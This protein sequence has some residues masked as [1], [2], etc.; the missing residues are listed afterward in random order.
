MG[1]SSA[2]LIAFV[3]TFLAGV[4]LSG[5]VAVNGMLSKM[6]TGPLWAAF[7]SFL[8]G[9]IAL[10]LLLIVLR[11]PPPTI[12]S[13]SKLPKWYFIG[14]FLGVFY[15]TIVTLSIGV[16]GSVSLITTVIIAQLITATALEHFGLLG[17]PKSPV[18]LKTLL[19]FGLMLTGFSMIK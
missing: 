18:Q 19:G 4:A 2:V 14:G 13:L 1:F 15:V 12:S 8:I 10:L 5:Q 6:S 16:I 3:L 17:V 9:T 11:E 7:I